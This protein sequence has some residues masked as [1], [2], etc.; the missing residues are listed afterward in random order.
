MYNTP[1]T[2]TGRIITDPVYHTNAEK[3][4]GVLRIRIASSRSY[5]KGTDWQNIDQLYI[6]VEAWGR[7]GVNAHQALVRGTAVIV[8]GMLYTNQ[9]ETPPSGADPEAKA[10]KNQEIRIRAM[11]I[12]V[13]MNYYKVGYRDARP[14]L[15]SNLDEVELPT[16]NDAD[17][18][19]PNRRGQ[20]EKETPA[21]ESEKETTGEQDRELVGASTAGDGEQPNY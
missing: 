21:L 5:R 7:L 9:W 17:Y 2:I 8:Q 14:P 3:T 6:N 11:S 13:D 18:P 19:D 15:E 16:S 10:V 4:D 12:G 20:T 1:I